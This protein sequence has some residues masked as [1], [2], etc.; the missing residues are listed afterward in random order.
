M[1]STRRDYPRKLAQKLRRI[2]VRAGMSQ[3]EIAKRLGVKD[4]ALISQF[5][6]GKRQPSL[7]VLL[8]YARL[9]GVSTDVL[10][11]DKVKL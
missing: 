2:R 9:A 10:I 6:S 4:R 7:P 1:G 3:T 11:D 8:K 5:E